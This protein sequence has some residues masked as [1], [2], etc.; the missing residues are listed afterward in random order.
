MVCVCV[1][2]WVF[3]F[4][5]LFVCYT[6]YAHVHVVVEGAETVLVSNLGSFFFVFSFVFECECTRDRQSGPEF[7]GYIRYNNHGD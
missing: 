6:I 1:F 2:V 3:G 4:C 5:C 7:T